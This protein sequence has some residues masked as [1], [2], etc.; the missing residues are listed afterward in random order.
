[1]V[2][3]AEFEYFE[4]PIEFC[5]DDIEGGD[6]EAFLVTG[7]V[8]PFGPTL[9]FIAAVGRG[10]RR[11]LILGVLNPFKCEVRQV[12]TF[13]EGGIWYPDEEFAA[14]G[15]YLSGSCPTL[16]LTNASLDA[17]TRFRVVEAI[18][19]QFKDA[20]TVLESVR[21]FYG[22]PTRRV[23]E[24]VGG[25]KHD[26]GNP[27]TEMENAEW[28]D[29]LNDERHV[30]PEIQ[31]FIYAWHGS[32]NETDIPDSMKAHAFSSERMKG[33]LFSLLDTVWMPEKFDEVGKL[34]AVAATIPLAEPEE[35]GDV[36]EILSK[37]H[38]WDGL[39]GDDLLQVL[40]WCLLLYGREVDG[41][42]VPSLMD[43][44][45][46]VRQHTDPEHRRRQLDRIA[47]AAEKHRL[48][49]CTF[50]PPLLSDDDWSVV[51]A[52][53]L[54]YI[55]LSHSNAEGLPVEFADLDALFRE[56]AFDCPGG[57]FGGL[58]TSGDRRFH[59]KLHE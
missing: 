2:V 56:G 51:S 42:L 12:G 1:M 59:S 10:E 22:D 7:V 3:N 14:M 17:H 35:L 53:M 27:S 49:A 36:K 33:I 6:F 40:E 11:P 52:A 25:N 5:V 45:H 15:R 20:E 23:A 8:N 55:A 46:H 39:R 47:L 37:R 57:A 34:P 44:Y 54:N 43:L 19:S 21:R 13:V 48:A 31:S 30:Y 58:I 18:I 24:L 29:L 9:S 50:L 26:E 16:M 41:A 28:S 38:K 32:I 4:T